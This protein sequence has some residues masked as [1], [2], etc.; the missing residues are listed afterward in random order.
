MMKR[1]YLVTVAFGVA[2]SLVANIAPNVASAATATTAAEE[3]FR[4]N[5]G[6]YLQN[7]R[8]ALDSA[9]QNPQ[10]RAAIAPNLADFSAELSAAQ[11]QVSQLSAEALDAMQNLT[12]GSA[13]WTQQPAAIVQQ[14]AAVQKRAPTTPPPGFLSGC[15][16]GLGDLRGLFYGYWIAAQIASAASAVA[17]G[18]PSAL[19]FLPGLIIV[20]VIFG[21]AN[22]I[23]IGLAKNLSLSGDCATAVANANATASYPVDPANPGV[24]AHASS[25]I[26]VDTLTLLTGGIKTTL[27][28]IQTRTVVITASLTDL[29][30][31]LAKAQGT[32]NT[33]LATVTDLQDRS[34]ALLAAVGSPPTVVNTTTA[35]G[36]ANTLNSRLDTILNNTD[37]FQKLSV[38]AEIERS[39]ADR[40]SPPVAIFVLPAV[41]GGYIEVVRSVVALTIQNEL[42]AGQSVGTA[43]T[44]LQQGDA[45][46]AAKNY[47]AAYLAYGASYLQ[48]VN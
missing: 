43:Q 18:F 40:S 27:D 17:A 4:T 19:T 32:A 45:A 28:D 5:V 15:T 23:A 10:T 39:L 34:D 21:V 48:A 16:D 30:N 35:N 46:L 22:G 9:A 13:L 47:Q 29:I 12:G 3:A 7:L 36:L 33:I 31:S 25:Q 42:A 2:V 1:R 38:R 8:A 11:Q 20:A 24:P 6:T 41:Q 44:N 37:A 26:S 14:L